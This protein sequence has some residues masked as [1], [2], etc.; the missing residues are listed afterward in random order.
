MFTR[1][2]FWRS[3]AE[4]LRY[5]RL[6]AVAGAGAVVSAACFGGGIGMILPTLQLLLGQKQPLAGLLDR[7]LAAP[8]RPQ[9]LRDL[10][11]WL[12]PHLPDDPF[13]AFVL[14]MALIAIL[15]V[16]GSVGRYIHERQTL[17]IVAR[18]T[19]LWRERIFRRLV[20][21]QLSD[22]MVRGS[23]DYISRLTADI[24][25][26]QRGF[27]AILGRAVAK[28]F[29]G[30]VAI[31]VAVWIDWQLS[32]IAMIGAPLVVYLFRKFGTKIRRVT[33]RLMSQQGRMI[34]QLNEALGGIRV[35]KVHTAEGYER[36][37]FSQTNRL[38]FRQEMKLRRTKALS[39][40]LI[41]A[42]ALMSIM[43]GAS[44]A[45]WHIFRRNVAPE[46]FMTVL[47]AL[48]GAGASLKPISNLNHELQEAA[49]A[50]D[51]LLQMLDVPIEPT[52]WEDAQSL[53]ILPTH[54]Q[55]L[56]FEHVSYSYPNQDRPAIRDVNLRVEHGQT[57][58]IV[59][60]NGSGKTTLLNLVPRLA[61]PSSG[62]V[63]IDGQDIAQVNLRS[64]RRQIAVVTQ[65]TVLFE[66]TIAQNIA[67]GRGYES[68]TDIIAAAKSAYAD[69]FVRDLPQ[70]YQT[71]LGEGGEGLSGGQK[72]RLCIA[73]AILRKPAILILDEATSQI[74]ADSEAKINLALRDFRHNR[75]TLVIAHRL[76]TVI[77]ADL[78]VVMDKGIIVDQGK[79]DELLD[80]CK[81][82][83]MLAQTQLQP[84]EV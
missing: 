75:T 7:Y 50:A 30:A 41:E 69:E 54:H 1:E 16:V 3:A 13:H 72:Q 44:V 76:S 80:R 68:M 59:G 81:A 79:H 22:L 45:A 29:N 35:V 10:A 8:D 43:L 73:R 46:Q 40:P 78:I 20:H 47:A 71:M 18:A 26:L 77:D 36:R 61:Q 28:I 6:L 51:R 14:V 38:L 9:S 11:G 52:R 17:T 48:V 34:A 74:D 39:A 67:Y 32:M 25:V 64:L 2:P 70:G 63:V 24:H 58:A 56:A 65:Q 21:A 83:R 27:Y 19:M 23:A 57:V 66:G 82:Y 4:M 5:K 49:A 53:P 60:A 31:A 62:R 84:A 15:T 42:L 12:N 55:S 37:R 33:R